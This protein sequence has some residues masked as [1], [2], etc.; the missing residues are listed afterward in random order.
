MSGR[1][2]FGKAA[3]LFLVG[4]S[5]TGLSLQAEAPYTIAKARDV[6][7][8]LVLDAENYLGV[9]YLFGGDDSK[10]LD[11]SGLVYRVFKDVLGFGVPRTAKTLYDFSE[12]I[13]REKLEPADLVFFDTTGPLAHVGIY[14]GD[15]MFISAASDGPHTGVIESSLDDPYWSRTFEGGGRLV[16][17]AGYLGLL[18]GL[19][20]GPLIGAD[21]LGRGFGLSADLSWPIRGIEP[22]IRV[23]PS[24]DVSLWVVRLPFQLSLGIDRR[25][26]FFAGPSLTLGRPRL[27][28]STGERSYEPSGGILGSAGVSW[29]PVEFKL[30]GGDYRLVGTL[31]WNRYVASSG[32]AADTQSDLAAS[33]RFGLYVESRILI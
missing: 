28:T 17:P 2:S 22:G 24:W 20:G 31:D 8:R 4:L 3:A 25:L 27:A 9:P 30:G 1:S 16:S 5:A 32:Q 29:A 11:C 6:R 10:G 13:D 14:A 12:R 19:G 21:N 23:A 15:G 18:L 33:L 7:A 26:S